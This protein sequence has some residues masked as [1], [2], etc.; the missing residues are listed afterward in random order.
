MIKTSGLTKTFD[1]GVE[2]VKGV[3]IT[4]EPGEIVGFLGP[5]GAGKPTNGLGRFRVGNDTLGRLGALTCAS[6]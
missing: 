3:D 6:T 5:N 2:A 4:V 1:G